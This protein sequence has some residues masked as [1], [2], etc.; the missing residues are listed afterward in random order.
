MYTMDPTA[1]ILRSIETLSNKIE[2]LSNKIDNRFEEV[3]G[4]VD[5][6]LAA[7]RSDVRALDAKVDKNFLGIEA[8]FP[9]LYKGLAD[10]ESDIRKLDE[11]VE[12]DFRKLDEKVDKKFLG[13]DKQFIRGRRRFNDVDEGLEDVKSSLAHIP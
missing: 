6:K 5:R 3:S 10:I 12:S 2:T 13:V 9:P 4:L 8:C 11:K 1:L 7:I